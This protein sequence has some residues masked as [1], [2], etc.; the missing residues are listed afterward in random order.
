MD[1]TT[2]RKLGGFALIAGGVLLAAYAILFNALLPTD[3]MEE[4][5]SRLVVSPYWI[6]ICALA[7]VAVLLLTFGII[8]A[9]S[10]MAKNAGILGFT[11]F[12]ALVTAYILQIGE[13]VAEAFYYPGVASS[14]AGLE[15]FRSD[16]MM[17]HPAMLAF[18]GV[19]IVTIAAGIVLFSIA[20]IRSRVFPRIGGVLLILGAALYVAGPVFI[21]NV[22]GILLFA[23]ACCVIGR[24]T[25][26]A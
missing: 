23:V 12:I 20:L 18:R 5:F 13:L 10:A 22:V 16:A 26:G 21:V 24:A 1:I 2:L 8:A 11:G 6:P 7:L 15:V 19:Y 14:E 4:D 9:Y 25:R 3:M 17:T